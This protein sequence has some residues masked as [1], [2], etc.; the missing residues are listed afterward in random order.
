MDPTEN[1]SKHR[2]SQ[3]K[4]DRLMVVRELSKLTLPVDSPAEMKRQS[5]AAPEAPQA[6]GRDEGSFRGWPDVGSQP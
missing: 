3:S 6:S 4:E 2:Y 5:V 1:A